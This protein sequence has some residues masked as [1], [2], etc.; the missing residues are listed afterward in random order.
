MTAFLKSDSRI[1]PSSVDHTQP[2]WR[3]DGGMRCPLEDWE[4][5]GMMS[6][7]ESNMTQEAIHSWMKEMESGGGLR[8]LTF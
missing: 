8:K 6:D 4:E 7:W 5:E 2:G 1:S 3:W